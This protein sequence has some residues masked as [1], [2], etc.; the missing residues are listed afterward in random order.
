MKFGNREKVDR[1]P[2]ERPL[3]WK[4]PLTL[5]EEVKRFVR[6]EA[7]RAAEAAGM[8]TWEESQDFSMDDDDEPLSQY[9]VLDMQ[10]E[11]LYDVHK[12]LVQA[13]EEKQTVEHYRSRYGKGQSGQQDRRDSRRSDGDD[14]AGR[15]EVVRSRSRRSGRAVEEGDSKGEGARSGRVTKGDVDAD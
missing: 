12:A 1:T 14:D 10:E 6:I 8:E 3:H 13:E 9:E 5:Q 15:G 7:S 11:K 2:V 4:R